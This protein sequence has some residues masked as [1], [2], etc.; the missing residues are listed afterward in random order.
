MLMGSPPP[1]VSAV[2]PPAGF[3]P[4]LPAEPPAGGAGQPPAPLV[5]PLPPEL[6]AAPAA[7]PAVRVPQ[8]GDPSEP[9]REAGTLLGTGWWLCL[10]GCTPGTLPP[11]PDAQM[12]ALQ[13][14]PW[15]LFPLPQS[16]FPLLPPPPPLFLAS[17]LLGGD[18][19]HVYHRRAFLT[20]SVL[21]LHTGPSDPPPASPHSFQ[22]PPNTLT[23]AR[24]APGPH[25]TPCR[26]PGSSEAPP[27]K[28]Q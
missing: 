1:A 25:E 5:N 24:A 19:P 20:C 3:P 17:S 16:S 8:T 4:H 28:Y 6:A 9:D 11:A 10:A 27:R 22:P 26:T 2:L 14:T 7:P 23:G 18:T 15:P 12:Q 13:C 21:C